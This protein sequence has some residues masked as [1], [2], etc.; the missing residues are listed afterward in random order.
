MGREDAI[1]ESNGE[2]IGQAGNTA[3]VPLRVAFVVIMAWEKEQFG[4]FIL[5]TRRS[6]LTFIVPGD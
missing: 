6:I 1:T 3:V 2:G 4:S 5:P